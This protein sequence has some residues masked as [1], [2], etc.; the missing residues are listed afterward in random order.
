MTPRWPLHPAPAEGEALSSWLARIAEAYGMDL[1]DLLRFGLGLDRAPA[2]SRRLEFLD[3]DPP[4]E[5]LSILHE[6]TGVPLSEIRRMT[7]RGWVPWLLDPPEPEPGSGFDTYVRQ[8]SVLLTAKERPRRHLH[9]WQAW[10]SKRGPMRRACPECIATR[11]PSLRAL[12]LVSQLPLTISCPAHA[13]MLEPVFAGLGMIVD[14]EHGNPESTPVSAAVAVMDRRTHEALRTGTVSL[15]RRMIHAGVWF[16]L[17][18]TVIDELS[19]RVL[20]LSPRSR[21]AVRDIWKAA[22]YRVR[23][24]EVGPWKPFEAYP[25]QSQKEMLEAAATVFQLVESGEI[26]ARGS[27]ADLLTVE[28]HRQIPDGTPPALAAMQWVRVHRRTIA[29]AR[30]DPQEARNLLAFLAWGHKSVSYGQFR[31]DLIALG[32][33]EEHLPPRSE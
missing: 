15:P 13:C 5:L 21:E 9:G 29:A 8:D 14:W 12:T 2:P 27:L 20:T 24:G 11:P 28:P 1:S 3:V 23:N 17:L 16:R 22:G 6:R 26:A 33:P 19:T 18:R 32:V 10:R 25:W 7:V 4:E 30:E 31:E